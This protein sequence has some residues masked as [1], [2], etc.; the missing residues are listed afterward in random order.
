V[1]ET[2]NAMVT[3]AKGLGRGG[4]IMPSRRK[5]LSGAGGAVLATAWPWGAVAMLADLALIAS[6][7]PDQRDTV[8]L[9]MADHPG[10][11]LAETLEMLNAF[12]L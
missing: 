11:S 6:L 3:E 5:F 7:M 4:E 9:A 10:V 12:G 1:I 8:R 2:G